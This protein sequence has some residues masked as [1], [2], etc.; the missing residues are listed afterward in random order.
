MK[1]QKKF[2]G[3]VENGEKS[4]RSAETMVGKIRE[5]REWENEANHTSWGNHR[6]LKLWNRKTYGNEKWNGKQ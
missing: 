2:K 5:S 3:I 4:L 6:I 1:R